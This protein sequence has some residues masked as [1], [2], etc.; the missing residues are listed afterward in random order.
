MVR[1]LYG[2]TNGLGSASVTGYQGQVLQGVYTPPPG[3]AAEKHVL[4]PVHP[5]LQ[6]A[7]VDGLVG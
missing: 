6:I 4:L 1:S 7:G 2:D 5:G 3:H